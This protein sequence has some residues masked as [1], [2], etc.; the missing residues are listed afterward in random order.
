MAG[1]RAWMLDWGWAMRGPAWV[2]TA[3]LILFLMEA[4]WQPAAAVQ[5]VACVPAW[6]QTP[7]SV[8]TADAV[9][10]IRSWERAVRRQP[11]NEGFLC[12]LGLVR[13]WAAYRERTARL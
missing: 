8:I 3:R 5:A 1:D 12:W 4:G 2:T 13:S 7:P 11:G 6:A 9:S 10:S